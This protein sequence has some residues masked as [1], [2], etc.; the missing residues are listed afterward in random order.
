MPP[1]L[2]SLSFSCFSKWCLKLG[3]QENCLQGMS[4]FYLS[5]ETTCRV[6][7]LLVAA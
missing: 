7:N 4:N 2:P 6:L 1:D 3:Q 5:P